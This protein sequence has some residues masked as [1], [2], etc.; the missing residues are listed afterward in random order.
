M[1]GN[2]VNF[3]LITESSLCAGGPAWPVDRP[4]PRLSPPVYTTYFLWQWQSRCPPAFFCLSQCPSP[5]CPIAATGTQTYLG[6]RGIS[7]HVSCSPFGAYS[8]L[9]LSLSFFLLKLCFGEKNCLL[10]AACV[11][12]Y[13]NSL[14]CF[15]DNLYFCHSNG[16]S[17]IRVD[18]IMF[19]LRMF[20]WHSFGLGFLILS[21][22]GNN[23]SYRRKS[24][25]LEPLGLGCEYRW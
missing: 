23:T 11:Y 22:P 18:E 16:L 5:S 24:R 15:G 4:P 7:F 19:W 14:G 17:G 3:H 25:A 9:Q 20:N 13:P 8:E 1:G 12:Q 6:T 10:M 21:T 2:Y